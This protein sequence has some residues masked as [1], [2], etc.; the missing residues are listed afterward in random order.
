VQLKVALPGPLRWLI[1][2]QAELIGEVRGAFVPGLLPARRSPG[3]GS[4][5]R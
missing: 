3:S 2:D 1:D 5:P 4:R